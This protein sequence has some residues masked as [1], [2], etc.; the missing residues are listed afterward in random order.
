MTELLL[1]SFTK[2]EISDGIF[3]VMFTFLVVLLIHK[4]FA[5][6]TT[7][8]TQKAL[9]NAL[10]FEEYFAQRR[11]SFSLTPK[12]LTINSP[13]PIAEEITVE[14]RDGIDNILLQAV[15]H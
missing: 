7:T 13:I 12:L 4:V 6:A 15:W 2:A 1:I 9:E 3:Y 5:S 11:F 10:K 14:M 8:S